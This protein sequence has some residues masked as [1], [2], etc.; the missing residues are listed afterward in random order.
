MGSPE[1]KN[2]GEHR[3]LCTAVECLVIA[4]ECGKQVQQVNEFC[5]NCY[6]AMNDD[7]NTALAIGHLFNIVKKINS[8]HI[9]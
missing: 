9:N 1:T 3:G 2:P 5:D 8:I 6:H 7:F 4:A